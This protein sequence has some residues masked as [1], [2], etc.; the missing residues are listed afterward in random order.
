MSDGHGSNAG[1]LARDEQKA[2]VAR[3]MEA[4]AAERAEMQLELARIEEEERLEAERQRQIAEAAKQKE[5][6]TP[7]SFPPTKCPLIHR[8]HLLSMPFYVF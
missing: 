6:G 4:I 5:L 8:T 7:R 3:E 1:V 2:T